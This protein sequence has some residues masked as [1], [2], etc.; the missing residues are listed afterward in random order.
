MSTDAGPQSRLRHPALGVAAL[1][2]AAALWSLNGVLIKQ[3]NTADVPAISI[4]CLRSL[5]GGAV[6]L[7]FAWRVRHTLRRVSP[8]WPVASVIAFTLMTSTFVIATTITTAANAIILQYTSAIWVFLLAP[9]LIGERARASE[10]LVLVI[11]MA[12]VG[13]IF[14]GHSAGATGPLTGLWVALAS[15]FG[16]GVLTVLLRGL[17][18]V[19]PFVVSALNALGSGM[20]LV[21]PTLIWGSFALTPTMWG[22]VTFMALVQ[23]VGPYFLFSWALQHVPAMRGGLIVLLE[24]ILNP[25]WAFLGAGEAPHLSTTI[26]GGLILVGVAG[27][28]FTHRPATAG[29]SS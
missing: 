15:G 17:R 12:G 24:V 11:A 23:F 28:I 27:A 26:G 2:A 7:P 1:V 9:L 10:G 3:L 6:F 25:L 5:I 19:D 14:F 22:A 16:Y 8:R 29:A 21:I 4:A 20:L 18:E 13:V